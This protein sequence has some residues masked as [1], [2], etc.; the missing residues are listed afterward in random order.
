[1]GLGRWWWM[2]WR[3]GLL[4]CS[5]QWR[6]VRHLS[7][8]NSAN[9]Y[10]RRW[11]RWWWWRSTSTKADAETYAYAE[12]GRSAADGWRDARIPNW[13][14]FPQQNIWDVFLPGGMQCDFGVCV[15][16]GNGVAAVAAP[17]AVPCLA[18]GV[19]AVV[20]GVGTVAIIAYYYGPQIV[21][22]AKGGK[23][24]IPPS[25]VNDRPRPGESADDFARRV[26][27]ARYGNVAGCGSGG[28]SE[29]NKIRKWAQ[30]W[31]NKHG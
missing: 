16:I 17:L 15:P 26:C 28:G 2:G 3:R 1:M 14:P 21:Q 12:H 20:V 29:F 5:V 22:F 27:T 11:R 6:G 10:R 24:N 7:A 23:Q 18:S 25:W 31:I 4:P 9:H 19:C 30:D 13:F 8:D